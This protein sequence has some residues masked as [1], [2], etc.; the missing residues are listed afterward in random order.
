[1]HPGFDANAFVKQAS[2]R[3]PVES[4]LQTLNIQ[5]QQFNVGSEVDLAVGPELAT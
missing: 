5:D 3:A 4:G 2:H 1:M